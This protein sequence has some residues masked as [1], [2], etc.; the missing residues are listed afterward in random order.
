MQ[1]VINDQPLSNA[2]I[3]NVT[4]TKIQ[5][6][7]TDILRKKVPRG[8]DVFTQESK[9]LAADPLNPVNKFITSA[10]VEK[11]FASVGMRC[12]VNDIGVYQ[13]AFVHNSYLIATD[14][15][16]ED[17][18]DDAEND[19]DDADNSGDTED[20][21]E[22]GPSSS[23][24]ID[25]DH[26]DGV[27]PLQ[28]HSG[29]RLEYLGDAVCG[30]SVADYLYHR[31]PG[32]D[33]GFMTRLRTRIVCG[34]RLGEFAEKLGLQH[35]AV[36]S[37]Y[38]EAINNGRKNYKVL[39]DIFEAFVGAMFEDNAARDAMGRVADTPATSKLLRD[40]ARLDRTMFDANVKGSSFAVCNEF[41]HRVLEKY[42]DFAD[43]IANDTN[44][45]DQ[46]L[47]YYQQHF[48]GRFPIYK[49]ISCD[50]QNNVK[51]YTMGV[52]SP[53]GKQVVGVGVAKKKRSSEQMA[54]LQAL[55]YYGVT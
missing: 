7:G 12:P 30:L 11:I 51:T 1:K 44:H 17:N 53:D 6:R 18:G 47:R 28:T 29:E 24:F 2:E 48:E 36:I 21:E 43:L 9:Q 31:Y 40:S 50:V 23:R 37:R 5:I 42:I 26:H 13:Q 8:V 35:F 4:E 39:E 15:G 55:K 22:P 33:E 19:E 16:K 45:K 46:L 38:V 20:D 41:M 14:E 10:D 52:L 34:S 32:E 25:H 3:M 54:S 49:Q 27:M